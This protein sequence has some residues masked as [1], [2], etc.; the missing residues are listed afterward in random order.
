MNLTDPSTLKAFLGRHGLRAEKKLGQH[1]LCSA[2]VVEAIVER[3]SDFSGALEIGPGPGVLTGPLSQTMRLVA[4]ELDPRMVESLKDSAPTADV[5]L[6]DALKSNLPALLEELPEPRAVVGNLP[7]YITGQLV[8]Q[9]ADAR[10]HYAAAVLMMQR[11]VADRI[12]AKPGDSARGSLSVY[13]QS[14]FRI[15]LVIQ[16]PA[17]AFFPPPKV[18]STVLE[19]VPLPPDPAKDEK[20]FRLVRLGFGQPR[21]TL[22]NNLV[23]GY[24]VPRE[25]AVAWLGAAGLTDNIRPHA[26]TLEEWSALRA[27]I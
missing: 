6:Q 4:L 3:L 15:D 5:R 18:D 11:E 10:A 1:F 9:I 2:P 26:L 25:T 12:R 17:D 14:L 23:A 20:Y 21:K 24:G 19:F 22:C 7:Y 13:L 16:A 27:A 8:A